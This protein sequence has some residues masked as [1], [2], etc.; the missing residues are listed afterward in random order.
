MAI[1][2]VE[3]F[4]RLG[5]EEWTNR[6]WTF[7]TTLAAAI[8]EINPIINAERSF[9]S[10]QVVFTYARVAT[11]EEGDDEFAN[12]PINLPGLVPGSTTGGLLP[13]W[14]VAKLYWSKGYSRPDYKLYR[15]CLGELNTDS[16]SLG[17]STQ[18]AID[19]AW[20]SVIALTPARLVSA[21][22]I[23]YASASVDPLIRERQ[24]HRQR[25]RTS[26]GGLV[27]PS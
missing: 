19:T 22:G 26:S 23:A 15:G 20:D 4:K 21:D 1:F 17:A 3:L 5:T 8:P 2:K 24:L 10:D 12:V 14:N 25:R 7:S 16:G 27:T 13:L 11:A 9:H 6:Y 18:T